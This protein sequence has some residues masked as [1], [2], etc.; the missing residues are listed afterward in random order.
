L[1][2]V[3]HEGDSSWT[4]SPVKMKGTHSFEMPGTSH[5]MTQCL[6]PEDQGL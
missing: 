6:S 2:Q 5:T 3:V 1:G 4:I